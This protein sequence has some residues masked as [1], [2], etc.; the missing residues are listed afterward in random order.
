MKTFSQWLED[1]TKE[2]G[3]P[4]AHVMA[5]DAWYYAQEQAQNESYGF[6]SDEENLPL[7]I[8]GDSDLKE[9]SSD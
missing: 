6:P 8:T 7:R 5:E 3:T 2:H 4:P 9:Q 1:Y